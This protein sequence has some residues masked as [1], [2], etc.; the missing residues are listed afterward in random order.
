[1]QPSRKLPDL[2]KWSNTIRLMRDR[3]GRT[4]QAIRETFAAAN[5]D[6]FWRTNI[7]SPDTLRAKFDDLRLRLKLDRPGRN[8][9]AVPVLDPYLESELAEIDR[10]KASRK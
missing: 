4:D 1:M 9:K 8:G 2:T 6:D 5:R 3:D 7:L 10:I